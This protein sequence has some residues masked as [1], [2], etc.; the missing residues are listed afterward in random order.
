MRKEIYAVNETKGGEW[1]V[2]YVEYGKGVKIALEDAISIFG[3][4]KGFIKALDKELKD[5][6]PIYVDDEGEQVQV[7]TI[8]TLIEA[9]YGAEDPKVRLTLYN[10]HMEIEK[11]LVNVWG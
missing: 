11:A 1:S 6:S 2:I 9:V 5:N 4:D 7:I 3:E 8:P 10:L